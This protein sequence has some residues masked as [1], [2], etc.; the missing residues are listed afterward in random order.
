[1]IL[2]ANPFLGL[3]QKYSMEKKKNKRERKEEKKVWKRGCLRNYGSMTKE[4]G[5]TISSL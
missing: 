5:I 3:R 2:V 1:M 4:A